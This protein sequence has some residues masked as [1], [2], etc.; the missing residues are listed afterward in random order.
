M[1]YIWETFTSWAYWRYVLF[2]LQGLQSVLAIFGAIYL[3]VEALNFFQ[4][5]TR[6][7]Y[8]SAALFVFFALSILISVIFRRPIKSTTITFPNVDYLI[9]VRIGDLFDASG[10]VMVSSNTRFEADV[11]GGK[12]A[13][14]SL[15]GQFTSRYFTG[16]QQELIDE[17]EGVL[18]KRGGS[19]PYPIGSVVPITTHGKTF[20]F[21][22]M[23]ELN[24]EGNASSTQVGIKTAL[25]EL[26]EFI[27]AEGELQEIAVPLVGTGRGRLQIPKRKM[28]ELIAE[29]FVDASKSGLV[30]DRLVIFV[31]DED[32]QKGSL[33]LWEVKDHLK[34]GL[35]T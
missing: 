10:A 32:A 27:R 35:V 8:A 18:S 13:V 24:A 12:I 15:Q 20:Y 28:I 30:S 31:R 25:K 14:Q 16:N 34:R 6:D 26:W 2:S 1:R 9:E 3:V 23:A 4:V 17:I 11:A 33:N 22:A 21:L 29:S 5:F 7:K 19:G